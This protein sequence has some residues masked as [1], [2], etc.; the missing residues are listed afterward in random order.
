MS[1][2]PVPGP[3]PHRRGGQ[4]GNQNARK[5]GFYARKLTGAE[6]YALRR[7]ADIDGLDQ[8][9]AL[10]RVKI[11]SSI[12][13]SS[14]NLRTITMAAETLG[15]L[16]RTRLRL[17]GKEDKRKTMEQVIHNVIRDI[18]VPI[19]EVGVGYMI[20]KYKKEFPDSKF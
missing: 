14:D 19:G 16:L 2:N 7:A 13:S 11:Q 9:I 3:S 20:D 6:K 17:S 1:L 12:N 4:P 15:R 8:E 5:H 10:M 18:A